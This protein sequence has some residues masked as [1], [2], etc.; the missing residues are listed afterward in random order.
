[1]YANGFDLLK[2]N[3]T[4]FTEVAGTCFDHLIERNIEEPF[5]RILENEC[6]SDH[7]QVF[8]SSN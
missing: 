2:R 3:A 5:V 1:M 6:F 7:C 8:C 4:R